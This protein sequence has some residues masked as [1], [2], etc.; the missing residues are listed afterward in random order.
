[1]TRLGVRA[2]DAMFWNLLGKFALMLLRFL[3]SIVLVR[4]LGDAEYGALSQAIN[5][6][7][8][9]VLVAA[10]GLE[11]A[12][13]R[14]VPET[15]AKSG[16]AGE[17]R[18]VFHA[19]WLRLAVSAALAGLLWVFAPHFAKWLLHDAARVFPIRLTAC[20][21]IA[22]GFSNLLSR[23][24]VARYEQRFLNLTQAALTAAYLAAVALVVKLGGGIGGAL[25]CMIGLNA[26]TAAVCGWRWRRPN[27]V[28]PAAPALAA[29]PPPTMLRMLRFSWWTYLYN[30]LQFFFQKGMDVAL[31]GLLLT[32]PRV[33]TWYVVAY[34][35]VFHA[36]SFFSYAFSEG[37]SLAMV[38]EVAAQGDD[39]KLRRIFAVSMEY[40]YLFIIPICLGGLLIGGDVLRLFYPAATAAGAAAPMYVLLFGLS[41]SKMGAITANFLMGFDRE[42]TLVKLRLIFG[43][44]YFAL[45]LALIPLWQQLGPAIA[46]TI[47][48]SGEVAA[49]WVVVHRLLHPVYPWRFLAKI[50]AAGAGMALGLRLLRPHLPAAP[51]W[52]A[53]LLL[54]AGSVLFVFLIALARPFRR[55]HARL[56]DA[57]PLPGKAR[58]LP[59]LMEREETP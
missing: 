12:V 24:L 17:R 25:L 37:F 51:Y 46:M 4:L 23:V 2:A 54:A 10:A 38:S 30:F 36:V 39:E 14:F 9:L 3:E 26:A 47:A 31:L 32:D 13:L 28:A 52:R 49:E 18:L 15:L 33:T 53:P 44:A 5:L 21:L 27:P 22:M 7:A 56:L 19:V 35:L 59:W 8:L 20:L 1:M 34:N 40:L 16:E 42:K 50:F 6:N 11:N 43:A 29:E 41:F 48:L 45:D 55:E 57:L 58:W